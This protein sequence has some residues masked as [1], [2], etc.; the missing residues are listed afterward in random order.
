MLF[1]FCDR[2]NTILVQ[3]ADMSCKLMIMLM[4]A[5]K[6]GRRRLQK[7][8]KVLKMLCVVVNSCTFRWESYAVTVFLEVTFLG[9]QN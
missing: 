5:G 8:G 3:F 7:R 9:V 1:N 6:S 2:M 4:R